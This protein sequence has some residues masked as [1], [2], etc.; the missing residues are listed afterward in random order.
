V[1]SERLN[2]GD[3][4]KHVITGFEGIVT[5]KVNYLQGCT[6][7]CLQP[8]QLHPETGQPLDSIYFDEPYVDLVRSGV[9][10]VRSS[11]GMLG[12]RE[13]SERVRDDGPGKAPG[14]T[15]NRQPPR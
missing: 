1:D 7:V 11:G 4:A 9:V 15:A 5:A 14:R 3:L 6:Q 8:Q 12:E 13:E 10:A 2:L